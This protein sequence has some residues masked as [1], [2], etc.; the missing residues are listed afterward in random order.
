M[1]VPDLKS[2]KANGGRSDSFLEVTKHTTAPS[3]PRNN[4]RTFKER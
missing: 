3:Q 4:D 1:K 2:T